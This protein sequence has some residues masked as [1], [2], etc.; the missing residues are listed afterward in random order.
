MFDLTLVGRALVDQRRYEE[1]SNLIERCFARSSVYRDLTS[2][3]E[4]L[5]V[6]SRLGGDAPPAHGQEDQ[7]GED[8]GIQVN[9]LLAQAILLYIRATDGVD[10]ARSKKGSILKA[11]CQDQ[12]RS[13]ERLLSLR[14]KVI[15]HFGTEGEQ[16]WNRERMVVMVG[17][18]GM[19]QYTHAFS[20]VTYHAATIDDLNSVLSLA[21]QTVYE[22]LR[23]EEARVNELVQA[24]TIGDGEFR[25][26]MLAHQFDPISFFGDNS[27]AKS[28]G[29]EDHPEDVTVA[30]NVWTTAKGGDEDKN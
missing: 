7:A 9:A 17:A 2:A 10:R 20:R 15:A 5:D 23:S 24:A 25:S 8:L 6:I 16:L 22:S 13:H 4:C 27:V 18:D 19:W 3:R 21:T 29:M 14:N 1:L 28:F 12:R 11:Y 26:L 30:R